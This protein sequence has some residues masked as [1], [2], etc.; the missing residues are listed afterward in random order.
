MITTYYFLGAR[1]NLDACRDTLIFLFGFIVCLVYA[2]FA[3]TCVY[4]CFH[5]VIRCRVLVNRKSQKARNLQNNITLSQQVAVTD[6][7]K[8][9]KVSDQVINLS[10]LS[11]SCEKSEKSTDSSDINTEDEQLSV[12]RSHNRINN[13]DVNEVDPIEAET[14]VCVESR[15]AI[16]VD[17]DDDYGFQVDDYQRQ[18]RLRQQLQQQLNIQL[19]ERS[20]QLELLEQQQEQ[21]DREE[22]SVD[23]VEQTEPEDFADEKLAFENRFATIVEIDGKGEE[24]MNI[25][26][27]V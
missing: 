2:L 16:V 27:R 15:P 22:S 13:Q 25:T 9:A 26:M 20:R 1:I 6:D 21:N 23:I 17:D 8:A 10:S 3:I 12:D 18:L 7:I 19:I 14:G 11:S 5:R 4:Y 24:L